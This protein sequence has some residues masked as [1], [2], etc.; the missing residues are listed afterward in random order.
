M[1]HLQM[2]IAVF[3]LTLAVLLA[4]V[5]WHSYSGL[6]QEE[7]ARLRYFAQAI[8]DTMES[9]LATMVVREENR[10]V[11]EYSYT[12]TPPD[13]ATGA[14]IRSPLS[15]PPQENYIL[16]HLQNNPDGSFQTPLTP[17][18]GRAVPSVGERVKQLEVVNRI[19]NQKKTSGVVRRPRPAKPPS[20]VAK[21]EEKRK[22][23]GFAERFLAPER[24]QGT[25]DYLGRKT[26]RMEKI[27]AGQA[28]NL[29]RK[30]R[31]A[32]PAPM[33][34]SLQARAPTADETDEAAPS[35]P[36]PPPRPRGA[37]PSA[38]AAPAASVGGRFQ[39]EV[40]PLQSVFIDDE[41]LFMFRRIV[42]DE[43]IYRQGVVIRTTALLQHLAATHF[44]TQPMAAFA[45][46]ILSAA[47]EGRPGQNIQS[48]AP[49]RQTRFRLYHT[50]PAP[51]DF[52]QAAI[53]SEFVPPSASRRVLNVMLALLTTVFL[54]GFG[55][56]F[57]S[58]R[59]LIDLSERRTRFVSSVTHELK[60][61]L[62]NIRMYIEML[63]QGIARDTEREQAYLDILNTESARL[64]RLINNVLE[65]SR[66]EKNQR[67]FDMTRGDF[68]D[69]LGEVRKIMAAK[70][71]REDFEMTVVAKN[72]PTF[73]YDREVMIQV[74]INLIE[75]S[76]KFGRHATIRRIDLKACAVDEHIRITVADT[77]PGIP[78]QALKKI[79]DD[80]YRVEDAL[81]RT[82]GGTGIGLAL[83]R[84]F[85]T[86][87]GG[88]ASAANNQGPGC[89]ITL[90]LPRG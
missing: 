86:A 30:E 20:L 83:V 43:R 71:A 57:Y 84:K 2:I 77:G 9:E 41:T 72:L 40:A 8:I 88:S 60:T 48:G 27:T 22:D 15:R 62:T 25:A 45:R 47:D 61:P 10:A 51:F 39:V 65:L 75:N 6:A 37:G 36:A 35:A 17:D 68:Q 55:A 80:F 85:M 12:F 29:A 64:S 7:E 5:V 50:F 14:P 78:R 18:R 23:A 26:R 54:V 16:G 34:E 73:A 56:I 46:L 66:L 69:V 82:T 90:N 4:F 24:Q 31:P 89:T 19:F 63:A 52:L 32:D 21:A 13:S 42:I 11:D 49:I 59:T 74:L 1:K 67:T 38:A 81:T 87:M 53:A 28:Q 44:E 33:A 58:A 79:F 70:L 76:I 3:A